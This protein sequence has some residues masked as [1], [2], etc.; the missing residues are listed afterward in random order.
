MLTDAFSRRVLAFSLTF[1][2]PSYRACMMIIRECVARHNRLP[3][4]FVV[5]GGAEFDSVY[6]ET[7]LATFRRKSRFSGRVWYCGE[8]QQFG[9]NVQGGE[10]DYWARARPILIR[11]SPITPRPTHLF[12]PAFPL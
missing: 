6:F 5:D 9:E 12:I 4:I 3:Q 11:L 8:H 1:D 7:I 2:P 10:D